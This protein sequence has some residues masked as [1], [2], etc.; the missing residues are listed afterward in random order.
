MFREAVN[1]YPSGGFG[2]PDLVVGTCKSGPCEQWCTCI[3]WP[4]A[5]VYVFVSRCVTLSFAT[6]SV[7]LPKKQGWQQW[8]YLDTKLECGWGGGG[9]A[10]LCHMMPPA[11]CTQAP[12]PGV[13]GESV[14]AW[15]DPPLPSRAHAACARL[16]TGM[17]PATGRRTQ[18]TLPTNLAFTAV[19][20]AYKTH[21]DTAVCSPRHNP[22]PTR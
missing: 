5:S 21:Y 8:R 15:W 12:P 13:S 14:C 1:C 3:V 10:S 22:F 17:M 7:T 20:T 18:R 6:A 16:N 2:V 19:L 9:V 11:W 4:S